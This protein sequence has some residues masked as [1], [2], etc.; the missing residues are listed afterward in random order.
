MCRILDTIEDS[1]WPSRELKNE[2][3][4]RFADF[5]QKQPSEYEVN[6]W[7]QNFPAELKLEEKKLIEVTYRL[8]K[9]F[10]T[11]L[12]SE[13]KSICTQCILMMYK[14][15]RFYSNRSEAYSEIEL[16]DIRDLNRYCYFVAGT[17]GELLRRLYRYTRSESDTEAT[18]KINSVHFGLF[19]QKVNIIKDEP[20]DVLEGRSFI[21]DRERVLHSISE[22]A[23]GALQFFLELPVSEKGFRLFCAWS[24]FMGLATLKKI[25]S[26]K[27]YSKLV[28][29]SKE[30]TFNLIQYIQK[31]IDDNARLIELFTQLSADFV[32][33]ATASSP[34]VL[35]ADWFSELTSSFLSSQEARLL[36][37]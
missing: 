31:I 9:G 17:V 18:F 28:K 2:Q 36:Q 13:V 10:H 6:Q 12:P 33:P 11:E 14:G 27:P 3:M 29:L 35:S 20:Q 8:L 30:E 21:P 4:D 7:V 25:N 16:K 32:M 22:N 23:K 26:S 34:E 24:M 37:V 15:M 1:P 5:L 19:L